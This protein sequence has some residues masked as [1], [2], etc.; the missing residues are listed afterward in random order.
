MG[1][2]N[3]QRAHSAFCRQALRKDAKMVPARKF[4]SV[5]ALINLISLL[6]WSQ[7]ASTN[8]AVKIESD[9]HGMAVQITQPTPLSK[10]L[11][12]V[13]AAA[14]ATTTCDI[15]PNIGSEIIAPVQLKGNW[16]QIVTQLLDGSKLNYA[17]VPGNGVAQGKLI[18]AAAP[19]GDEI[20][21]TSAAEVSAPVQPSS[22][23]PLVMMSEVPAGDVSHMADDSANTA[24]KTDLLNFGLGA[25]D[26]SSGMT[27]TPYSGSSGR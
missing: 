16:M 21:H 18:V 7:S 27:I 22:S 4:L 1:A 17:I 5:V 10:V 14:A 11:E 12:S 25:G 19:S 6:A 8:T 3:H 24:G 13:C 2:W 23:Q 9:T 20:Q 15:A 26:S